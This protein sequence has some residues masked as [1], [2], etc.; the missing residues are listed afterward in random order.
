MSAGPFYGKYPG[1]VKNN[2]DSKNK[3]RLL[4]EVPDVGGNSL[5]SWALPCLP[6][7]GRNMGMFTVPPVGA[8]VW[9]E[10]VRGDA[11]KPIWVGGFYGEGD[12]PSLARK[13]LPS[14]SGITLQTQGDN[15]LVIRD[16]PDGG[17]LIQTAGGAKIEVTDTGITLSTG[18]GA[19]LTL[20]NNT[21]DVNSGALTVK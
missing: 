14:I 7:T 20:K 5:L 17:I 8:A 1:T 15:G 6:V 3:G 12:A 9:V 4:V 10:F 16:G 21:V 11:N 19:T 18:L 2:V 13:V